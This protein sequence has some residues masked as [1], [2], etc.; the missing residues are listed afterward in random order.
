MHY[1]VYNVPLEQV[2]FGKLF[3]M[4]NYQGAY[5]RVK[6]EEHIEVFNKKTIVRQ[7]PFNDDGFHVPVAS[8]LNGHIIWMAKDKPCRVM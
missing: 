8:I 7:S 4:L 6:T 3:L 1:E 5:M 2:E